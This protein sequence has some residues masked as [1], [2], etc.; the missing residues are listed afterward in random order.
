MAT[1]YHQIS[2]KESFSDCQNQ[3]IDDAPSFFVLLSE[4]CDF[5]DFIPIEFFNAF[6]QS[7]GRNRIYPLQGFLAAFI[8][9]KIFSIPTDAL[10]LLFLNICK[11]LRQFCGFSK[12]PDAS[13]L[14]RFKHDFEPYIELMFQQMVDFT[15]P[16]CQAID[17]SLAQ[18]LT[19]DTSGIELYVTENNPKTWNALIKKLKAYYKDNPNVNPY[20]MAYGLMP[21]QA[22]SCSDAKQMYI[23][24]HFCYADKFAIL[25]NGLGIVRHIAFIDDDDFKA[26]HPDLIIEKKT[27]SPDEDKSVGDASALVPVL[28]D[29]FTLHPDFHPNTFLGDSAF[30]SV[31]LYGILFRDFH[32]SKALIPYNPRNESSLKKVG[33]NAYGY[34]TCPNDSSL[35]MKYC[36]VTKEK[37]RS[38]RVKWICPKLSYSHGWHCNCENPCSSA[39]KGRTTYTYE[40]MNLRMFPGIQRDSDEWNH[41]YKIRAIVE[42]AINHFKINMCI[43]GRKTRNHTTTKAD[44]FLAGIA[45]QLTVIVSYAMNC[46]QYIRSLKPLVA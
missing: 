18:M 22:A 35:D 20:Q 32:F 10:L 27:D 37:G 30:D 43:A 24:G 39:I 6:Y 21:S 3:L 25:T 9:Q 7:L 8:L 4:Y 16:I 15:E 45:S 31:D 33:Y 41:N 26:S 44:V 14:S 2:L 19:F 11:E 17:A 40:N 34:P 46:P 1:K 36:G 12:I 23:N 42:R 5:N 38:N 29:F 13:L 28:S